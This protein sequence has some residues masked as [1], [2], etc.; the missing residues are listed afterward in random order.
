MTDVLTDLAGAVEDMTASYVPSV[1]PTMDTIGPM[2]LLGVVSD[3]TQVTAGSMSY[4][5][6]LYT[7]TPNYK[8]TVGYGSDKW[9]TYGDNLTNVINL[10]EDQ[11]KAIQD[12][13]S[14][15]FG[16]GVDYDDLNA[17]GSFVLP[18]IPNNTRVLCMRL[19]SAVQDGE[20]WRAEWAIVGSGVPNGVTGDC[21]S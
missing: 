20:T 13:A 1:Q 5:Q 17:I 9:Q 10:N 14:G 19:G 6:W 2:F 15:S 7:V 21:G 12:A 4:Y 18:R 3:A 16:N 11:N 8:T